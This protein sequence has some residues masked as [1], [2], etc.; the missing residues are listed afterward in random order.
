MFAIS[1]ANIQLFI[2]E[3]RIYNRIDKPKKV[4]ET[5]PLAR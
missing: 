1:R 5:S 2:G 3:T 4:T